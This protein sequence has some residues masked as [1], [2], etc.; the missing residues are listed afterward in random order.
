MLAVIAATAQRSQD[1]ASKFMSLCDDDST[2]QC[3]TISPKMME[4]LVSQT[5]GEERNEAMLQA[6]AKLK[7]ARIV[8]AGEGYYDRAVELLQKN[9]RRFELQ[10]EFSDDHVHGAIYLRK[11]RRGN[12][13]ELVMLH[14]HV[15]SARLTVVNV[16]GDIDEEFLCFLY[17]NKSFKN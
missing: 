14:E 5:A 10:R 13:V 9:A 17:N 8:S 4:Q 2:V 16:T 1:F 11:N 7:S 3:V 12:A 15:Q 6:I